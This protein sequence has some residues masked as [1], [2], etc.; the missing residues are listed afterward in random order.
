MGFVTSALV[1]LLPDCWSAC[2]GSEH[3]QMANEWVGMGGII[4]ESC[5][6]GEAC[7][8]QEGRQGKGRVGA[9]LTVIAA[10]RLVKGEQGTSE[11]AVQ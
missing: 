10:C 7:S 3:Q 8:T 2:K 6:S 4:S 9:G 1:T 11:G 5:T